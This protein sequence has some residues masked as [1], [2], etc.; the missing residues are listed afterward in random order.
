MILEGVPGG[1]VDVAVRPAGGNNEV[2]RAVVGQEGRLPHHGET[3]SRRRNEKS[4][5]KLLLCS[6]EDYQTYFQNMFKVWVSYIFRIL[7]LKNNGV[8][9]SF[10]FILF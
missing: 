9:I 10:K 2:G 4:K 5:F 1:G 7:D 6:S 3:A 8:G